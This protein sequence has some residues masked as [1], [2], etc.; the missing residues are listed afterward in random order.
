VQAPF[1]DAPAVTAHASHEPA[2]HAV[3]QQTPSAQ[4]PLAHSPAKRQGAP[5][6]ARVSRSTLAL[7]FF[8]Q[9]EDQDIEYVCASLREVIEAL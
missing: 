1:A 8:V 2:S 5:G 6:S 3:S 7:P 9:L 4:K